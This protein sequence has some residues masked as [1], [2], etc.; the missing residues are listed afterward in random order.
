MRV[1][2]IAKLSELK[3]VVKYLTGEE[4]GL[5]KEAIKESMQKSLQSFARAKLS[6][7][8]KVVEYLTG[9]EIGLTAE[10]IKENMKSKSSWLCQSQ[11]Q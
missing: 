6:E 5:T 7:L 4:L 11:A 10:D 1:L 3:E 2:L 8:R 9:V